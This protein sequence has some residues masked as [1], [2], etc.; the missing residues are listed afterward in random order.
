MSEG[1]SALRELFDLFAWPWWLLALPLPWLARRLL[2]PR[3]S[4]SA[5]LKVPFDERLD[6]IATQGGGG[7]GGHAHVLAWLA[8][9]LLCIAAAR[10]QQLGP[11]IAPP[12]VGRDLM[13]AVDLS[14]SMSE[15]DMALGGNVVD[16][17]TAAKAVLADFLDRRAGDRIG[18]LVFGQ[19]AYTL[20]PLTLDRDSVRDQLRDSVVGLAGRETAIG[21]AIG[22]AVKRLRTQPAEQRVVILLT[23]G[24]N[25]AGALTPIKAAEL[26]KN[27]GVR[28]HTI[29]FGGEGGLSVFGFRLP[30]PGG[31]DEID[32]TTLEAVA[33]TTGGR[34]FRARDTETLAGIYAEIDRIEPV[35]RPGQRVRPRIERYPWPLAGALALSLLAFALPMRRSA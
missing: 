8:W 22:L 30:G 11:A 19:R 35:Q 23:D 14:G 29:A 5:A 34:F 31:E 21:D 3:R 10:P 7:A 4:A 6:A 25:T 17:L 1:L 2:P 28:V 27:D 32:E 16:R 26:A 13:L 18:L 9:G 15:E 20:T 24:V 33:K 12:Q